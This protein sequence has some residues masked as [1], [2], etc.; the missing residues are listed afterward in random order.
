[1]NEKVNLFREINAGE[2]CI[3][4]L[5]R[6]RLGIWSIFS[7]LFSS[8]LEKSYRSGKTTTDV[9]GIQENY[10]CYDRGSQL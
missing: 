8:V 4:L 10:S 7:P 1:M 9:A 3:I 5:L 6:A 2:K